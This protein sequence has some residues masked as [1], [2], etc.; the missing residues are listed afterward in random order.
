MRKACVLGALGLSL[1]LPG[2]ADA[3]PLGGVVVAKDGKRQAVVVASRT[4]VRTL[5][6]GRA[7]ARLR[8]GQRVVGDGSLFSCSASADFA[9]SYFHTGERVSL[10]CRVG[11]GANVLLV[12]ESERYRVGADGSVEFTVYGSLTARSETS[13][14]ARSSD[15]TDFTC[16]VPP[17]LDLSAFPVGT[18]VKL[19]CHRVDGHFRLGFIKSEKAV[20][21]VPH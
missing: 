14:T 2:A 9:L 21:E 10:R 12:A 4:S 6:P 20:V 5:R 8:V 18:Q 7:F 17:G 3:A 19:H 1:L 13:L 11:G 15:G 16:D